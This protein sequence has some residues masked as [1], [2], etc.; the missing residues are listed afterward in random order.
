MVASDKTPRETGPE[1]NISL[2]ERDGFTEVDVDALPGQK[3]I[4]ETL[5]IVS[6]LASNGQS[7][8]YRQADEVINRDPQTGEDCIRI[9]FPQTT[10]FGSF[11]N[12]YGENAGRVL[13]EVLE[14][15]GIAVNFDET[16]NDLTPPPESIA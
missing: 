5:Q 3:H 7:R 8:W 14:L 6:E 13:A 10:H 9:V 16:V 1:I 2:G 12:A 4:I 15:D 11:R